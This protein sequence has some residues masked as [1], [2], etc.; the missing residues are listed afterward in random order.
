NNSFA[1]NT[2]TDTTITIKVKG[3]TCKNDLVTL[4]ANVK[5]LNGVSECKP[6]KAGAVSAFTITFDASKVTTK[7][8][9]KAIEHTEGCSDPKDRPYKVKTK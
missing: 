5:Q 1:G 3:V 7:E 9:Y 6:G 4:S 2:A 8:I